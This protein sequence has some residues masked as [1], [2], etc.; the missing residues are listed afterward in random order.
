MASFA[1]N[2]WNSVFTPG[3]TPTLLYATNASFAALQLTLLALLAA[4]RSIHFIVLSFLC[5]GLWRAINWFAAE[6]AIAQAREAADNDRAAAPGGPADTPG[7][8]GGSSSSSDDDTEVDTAVDQAVRSRKTAGSASREVE[9]EG[10][11]A[12]EL[13][14]RSAA[15]A[16]AASGPA[17]AAGT[18][19]S[20][21][22]EDEWEKVS[23]NEN[24][25]D[26]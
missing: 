3:T 18:Q 12:G 5:A 7:G 24:E 8:G 13:K 16:A 1:E 14:Q 17:S 21:S 2:L 20:A 4:T 25:K 10:S 23:E 15:A 6:L 22:T 11:A 26:K 19:S 9:V